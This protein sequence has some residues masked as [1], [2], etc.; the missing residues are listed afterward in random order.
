MNRMSKLF[1]KCNAGATAIEYAMVA[2]GIALAIATT[3][4]LVG[5]NVAIM[6]TSIAGGVAGI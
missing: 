3:V 1:F 2:A 6:W 4:Q 5:G